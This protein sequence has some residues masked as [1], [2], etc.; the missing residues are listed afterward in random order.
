MGLYMA[1]TEPSYLDKTTKCFLI[2]S[3]V[4]FEFDHHT[5]PY[6]WRLQSRDILFSKFAI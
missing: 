1:T 4:E 5:S 3:M 6:I 2:R